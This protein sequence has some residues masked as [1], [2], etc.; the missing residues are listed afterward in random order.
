M[1]T[2]VITANTSWYIFNFRASTIFALVDA[3]FKVVVL[4]ADTL[5]KKQIISLGAGFETIFM[6]Q[7]SKNIVKEITSIFSYWKAI[8]R[9]KPDII[10]SFTPKSNIYA[11]LVSRISGTKVIS[12]VSG[13][14][15]VFNKKSFVSHLVLK[16]YK[17]S[18]SSNVHVFFQN[19]DDRKLLIDAGCVKPE[20]SSR[21]F[22]SGVDLSRFYPK[23]KNNLQIK[24]IFVARL[25]KPKGTLHY[26]NVA[27]LLKAQYPNLTF[28]ILGV[29][30]PKEK[31]VTP[32]LIK[33]YVDD[34]TVNFLGKSD[35]VE[36]I[37]RDYDAIV[38]P[39]WYREGV[40]KALLEGAA[41]GL[42]I[43]TTDSVGCRDV[44]IDGYNGF[45]CQPDSLSSLESALEKYILLSP[46]ERAVIGSHSR[47]FAEKFCDEKN[48]LDEYLT[49]INNNI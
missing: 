39:S 29:F 17:L 25:L 10:L 4:T 7:K 31:E 16:L 42:A 48:I 15:G 43:I 12:N 44:V 35:S 37:I 2:I 6:E 5:Y 49:C 32:E 28:S 30:D 34:G 33:K 9:I 36:S 23:I 20:K 46:E 41:S 11:S 45:I 27:R 8:N 47:E 38:L 24:F 3:G 22:G 40:P 14:G 13:L 26:L 21:I 19:D 1:K 18:F